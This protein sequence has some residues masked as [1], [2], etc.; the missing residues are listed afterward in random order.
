MPHV[1]CTNVSCDV[2]KNAHRS[3]KAARFED[4]SDDERKSV[5][6]GV[7][8]APQGIP[9]D[10]LGEFLDWCEPQPRAPV[11]GSRNEQSIARRDKKYVLECKY[12]ERLR[13]F[14]KSGCA[15]NTVMI[16]SNLR[17]ITQKHDE[18]PTLSNIKRYGSA[19]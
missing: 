18:K 8:V 13:G 19:Y 17:S 2:Q 5:G 4:D 7:E 6:E 1:T 12:G 11:T 15:P 14:E 3:R 16:H 9:W 10:A